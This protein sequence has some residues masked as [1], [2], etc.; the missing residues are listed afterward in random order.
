[1]IDKVRQTILKNKLLDKGDHI[2]AGVSGGPDSVCLLSILNDLKD[3]FK[4]KI[5]V[6]HMNHM[7]RGEASDG[8]QSYVEQLCESMG[9]DCFVY[10]RDIGKMSRE[11]KISSEEAGRKARYEAFYEVRGILGAQK[12]AVAQNLN[13]QAETVLFRLIRGTG[14]DGLS[15]MDYIRDGV[16]IRPLLDITRSE[17][18]NYCREKNLNPR[19]DHTNLEPVYTRN[20]IRLELIPYI[21]ENFNGN[22]L[23]SL[24]R[25]A[26]IMREDRDCFYSAANDIMDRYAVREADSIGIPKEIFEKQHIAVKKRIM[27]KAF[28]EIG[29]D[30]DI[31]FVHLD[32]ALEIIGKNSTSSSI[33]FPSGFLM[34][35]GYDDI[36]FSKKIIER[37][38][39]FCYEIVLNKE[40]D[41]CQLNRRIFGY[42]IPREKI[43]NIPDSLYT[44]YFDYNKINGRINVRNRRKGD[45]FSPL[46]MKGTKKLKDFFIDEKIPRELRDNIPLVCCGSEVL[47]IIGYRISEKYKIDAGTKEILVIEYN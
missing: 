29:L 12:I 39:D 8:D 2:V 20:K 21:Q 31:C 14:P 35:I 33:D 4:I 5:S 42:I 36:F 27:L 26:G 23:E 37:K 32:K 45:V 30:K 13:D 11:L 10:R 18:E 22:I 34:R 9:I 19:I 41:I 38:E 25:M 1:M 24:G 28:S 16:I 40:I 44:K 3:E 15:G 7:L 17:I 46:G 6:V 43:G 47:W